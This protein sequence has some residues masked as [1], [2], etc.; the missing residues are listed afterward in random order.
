MLLEGVQLPAPEAPVGLEP[1][2][3]LL[4]RLRPEGVQAPLGVR[5]DL[6]QPRLAED[7][8]VLGHAGLAEAEPGDQ[9]VHRSLTLSQEV[10]DVT[11]VWLGEHLEGGH[12]QIL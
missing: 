10:E 3:Q 11:A 2:V 5:P 12:G 4:E 1:L 9:L 7:P 6:D 8:Q